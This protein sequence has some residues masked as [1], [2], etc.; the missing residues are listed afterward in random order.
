[1]NTGAEFEK[2]RMGVDLCT[3][4]WHFLLIVWGVL[5]YMLLST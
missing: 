3:V 4:Y 1:M 2:V 5:F